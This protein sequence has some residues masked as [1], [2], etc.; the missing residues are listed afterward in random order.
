LSAQG[1][2]IL[3]SVQKLANEPSAQVP[4]AQSAS[5]AQGSPTAPDEQRP[6]KLPITHRS[7]SPHCSLAEQL[8]PALPSVHVPS[9]DVGELLPQCPEL[10]SAALRHAEPSAPSLQ[11]PSALL[12]SP[13]PTQTR[14]VQSLDV[15]HG[16]SVAPPEQPPTKDALGSTQRRPSSQSSRSLHGAALIPDWQERVPSSATATQ[17]PSRQSSS[18]KQAEPVTPA[19]QLP[20]ALP[21]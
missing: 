20:A 16:A 3:P 13:P 19:A 2:P 17:L 5:P 21:S 15:R 11:V 4:A 6:A 14:L 18:S 8:A 12:R 10:H 1:W 9:L 7:P